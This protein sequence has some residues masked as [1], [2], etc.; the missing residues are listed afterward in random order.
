MFLFRA[1]YLSDA[2]EEDL[3][4]VVVS[5]TDGRIL[6]RLDEALDRHGVAAEPV[7]AWPMLAER[8]VGEAY[9]VARGELEHKLLAPLGLRRRELTARLARESGRAAGY[10]DELLREGEE[11]RAGLPSDGP[12]RARAY[13]IQVELLDEV[14]RA[15]WQDAKEKAVTKRPPRKKKATK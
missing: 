13:A 2:R 11:H 8:P 14:T 4:Q 15:A 12:E 9:R 1:R 6:R 5:L 3:L 10:Y 7:E